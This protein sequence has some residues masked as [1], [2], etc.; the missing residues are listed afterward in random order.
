MWRAWVRGA[1]GGSP[2]RSAPPPHPPRARADNTL[3]WSDPEGDP[4]IVALAVA[5]KQMNPALKVLA[6]VGGW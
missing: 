6:A 3:T 1:G 2:T 4:P 5:L